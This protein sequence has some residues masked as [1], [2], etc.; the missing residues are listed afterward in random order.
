[1][2][3]TQDL[4]TAGAVLAVAREETLAAELAEVRRFQAAAQWAAMHSV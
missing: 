1:M 4:D 3:A 2:A